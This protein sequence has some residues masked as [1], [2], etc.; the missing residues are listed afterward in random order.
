MKMDKFRNM[1]LC[2]DI[3]NFHYN[4]WCVEMYLSTNQLCMYFRRVTAARFLK[5]PH[6]LIIMHLMRHLFWWLCGFIW[7]M[8]AKQSMRMAVWNAHW[9]LKP[10]VVCTIHITISNYVFILRIYSVFL[11]RSLTKVLRRESCHSSFCRGENLIFAHKRLFCSTPTT[12][13]WKNW[14]KE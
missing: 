6:F 8:T 12:F 10:N 5:G 4:W 9:I 11:L 14:E 13:T 2:A 7:A 1:F 3:S